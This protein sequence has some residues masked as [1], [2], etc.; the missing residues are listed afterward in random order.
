M[1]ST[2][3]IN[4]DDYYKVL[5]VDR[6]ATEHEIGKAY[7]KL[8][9]KH[10]P[11]KNPDNKE[12]AEENFKR[13]TEAYDVL[14]SAEKRRIYDQVGKA[15]LNG[16]GGPGGGSG[17]VS[18]QQADDIFKAF[19]GGQDPFQMFFDGDGDG[20]P[21]GS[22]GGGGRRVVFQSGPGSGGKGGGPG[23]MFNMGDMGGM[24]GMGGKSFGKGSQGS[25]PRKPPT[26]MHALL[27]GTTVCVYGLQK[28]PEHNNKV[29]KISSWDE[30]RGRYEVSV[31]GGDDT[32]SLKPANVCQHC[33]IEIQGIE[34]QPSLNGQSAEVISYTPDGNRYTVKL[35]QKMAN[36]RDAIGLQPSNALLP[37]GTRVVV[38]GLS[39]EQFNGQM[40]QIME[41]DRTAMRY[42][43]QCQNGRQ[44]KIKLENVLC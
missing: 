26:P 13:I 25:R 34:S 41:V 2:P 4:S 7:K 14:N 20:T 29:G 30:D 21:F 8:A 23:M 24:P 38:C 5:G 9:L 37:K 10:H 11:D 35:K 39:N 42:Q 17:G 28:A 32:L 19:F 36:G 18:F 1:P 43:V 31:S 15:G 27:E 33:T 40:A 12:K 16:G 22:F 44:I 3:D 6:S